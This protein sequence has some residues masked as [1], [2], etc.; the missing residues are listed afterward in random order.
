M[1]QITTSCRT[2]TPLLATTMLS[3]G[4]LTSIDMQASRRFYEEVLG[5]EVVQISPAS[6][7]LRKGSTHVYVVVETGQDSTMSMIDH[8]GI[9]VAT[10]ADV[11]H[12]HEILHR[13]K[14]TYGI[15][16][17][18]KVMEQHGQYSFYFVDLDGNWWELLQAGPGGYNY[19]VDERRDL[20][21]RTDLD[22][23]DMDLHLAD[24]AIAERLGV[25][26]PNAKR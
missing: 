14:D 24:D 15:R 11:E 16:R 6:M 12:A 19:L 2:D 7:L 3:H 26:G 13:V 10:R 20:T 1:P 25:I 8:N 17:I 5:L 4:T 9:D 18:N 21:G 22:E 23:N